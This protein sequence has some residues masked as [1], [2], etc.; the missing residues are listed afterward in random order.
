MATLTADQVRELDPYAFLAV[1]GSASSIPAEGAPP[2]DCCGWPPSG[3]ARGSWTSAAVLAPP[4]YGWRGS[5][6]PRW[7]PPTSRH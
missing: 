1:L 6:A 7:L 4:Q 5:T 2:T 3:P